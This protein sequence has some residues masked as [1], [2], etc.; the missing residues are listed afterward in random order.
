MVSRL[1]NYIDSQYPKAVLKILS[2]GV[3][4]NNFK[5]FNYSFNIF[6]LETTET[7]IFSQ[8]NGN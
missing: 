2:C 3:E 5:S 4:I 1:S 7:D 6:L 8:E